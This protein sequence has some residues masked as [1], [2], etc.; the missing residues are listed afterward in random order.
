[1]QLGVFLHIDFKDKY[2]NKYMFI[3]YT[4][5]I[6]ISF[7]NITLFVVVVDHLCPT[8]SGDPSAT[9]KRS[10]ITTQMTRLG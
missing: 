6:F 5:F 4:L 9:P 7:T 2:S 10:D 8:G 1:M 3:S